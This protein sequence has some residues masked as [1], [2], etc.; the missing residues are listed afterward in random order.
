MRIGIISYDHNH[1]KTEQIVLRYIRDSRIENINIYGLPFKPRKAR[2]ILIPHRPE[3]TQG[4]S[5]RALAKLD[6][7]SFTPWDGIK[8]ISGPC[9]LFVICGAGILDIGF[10]GGKPV[11]NAHP[12]IIPTTRGLDSFKWAIYQGDPV[13]I[14][15]HLIDQEVDMGRVL[16]ITQT[17]ILSSDD[18]FTL[19]RRHYELELDLLTNAPWML[20]HGVTDFGTEKPAKMR[21]K[22]ET[23]A[24]MMARFEDWKIAMSQERP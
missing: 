7:V 9:D 1:L 10:A 17:P 13:G 12:G 21:M 3:M 4:A 14:T 5:V 24:E 22:R 23:E 18:I 19:A 15:L 8:D 11:I 2:D 20:D 16:S 6:K